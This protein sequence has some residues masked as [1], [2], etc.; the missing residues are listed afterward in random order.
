M[1][2]VSIIFVSLALCLALSCE[3]N[4][5]TDQSSVGYEWEMETLTSESELNL[6][7][8][9]GDE[10]IVDWQLSKEFAELWL[11]YGQESGEYPSTAE[12]LPIPI[13]V[14]SSDGAIRYY[15]FRI[16]D[17]GELIGS[18]VGAATKDYGCPIVFEGKSS[19]Y[20]ADLKKLYD[21]GKLT[22]E[23]LPRLVDDGYPSVVIGR[24]TLTKGVSGDFNEYINLESGET[25]PKGGIKE[26]VSY[27]EAKENY[28][29]L[30]EGLDAEDI[31]KMEAEIAKYNKEA[32]MFWDV[33]EASKGNVLAG[34]SRGTA[35]NYETS[36]ENYYNNVDG[37]KGSR[38]YNYWVSFYGVNYR[39]KTCSIKNYGACGAVAEGFVLD[40]L[41]AN[42]LIERNWDKLT[43]TKKR[44]ILY[45]KLGVFPVFGDSS[46]GEATWPHKLGSAISEYSNYKVRLS[47]C[48]CPEKAIEQGLPGISLRMFNA[49]NGGFMHYRPVIAYK[50]PGWFVFKW[51]QVKVLDLVDCTDR[52]NGS[53]ET[54]IPINM[55]STYN[56]LPK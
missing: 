20:S 56:V 27:D 19:G 13:A 4:V 24:T 2:K 6:L 3:Q 53:W 45:D 51:W 42:G 39:E 21:D 25:V 44:E 26:I 48:I 40:Y 15:E 38:M 7:L 16:I 18:I 14:Y 17:N 23:D 10:N 41:S 29:K 50:K 31:A 11:I 47:P 9:K 28:P 35:K 8:S 49:R 33:A 1:K 32:S 22:N 54:Y 46:V 36:L 52:L 43:Y 37:Y 12:L 30:F 34:I 5:N 55:L